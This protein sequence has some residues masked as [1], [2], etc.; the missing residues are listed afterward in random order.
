MKILSYKLTL[1]S[2]FS[3][4]IPDSIEIAE[5]E[6]PVYEQL[7]KDK[8]KAL[9]LNVVDIRLQFRDEPVKPTPPVVPEP[10]VDLS[11]LE[12][13]KNKPRMMGRREEYG[14]E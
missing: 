4:W 11:E 3:E 1:K 8:Y 14:T 13:Y 7:I 10:D 12:Q 5:A 9:G 2:I 6:R